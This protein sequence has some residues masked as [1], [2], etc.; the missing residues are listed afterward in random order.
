MHLNFATTVFGNNYLTFL[1][2]LIG[3]L[4]KSIASFKLNVFYKDIQVSYIEEIN[5]SRINFIDLNSIKFKNT[6]TIHH[7]ISSKIY[8]WREALSYLPYGETVFFLDTDTIVNKN[9]AEKINFD[10]NILFTIKNEKRPINTGVIIVKNND[11]VKDFFE[12]WAKRTIEIIED[13]NLLNIAISKNHPYG[14]ADQMSFYE[15][16]NFNSY[17]NPFHLKS[18]HEKIFTL[19]CE[20]FNQTNSV[21]LNKQTYIYHFKGGWHDV[22][23]NGKTFNFKRTLK[24]SREM[25]IM[26]NKHLTDFSNNFNIYNDY[27]KLSLSY[28]N[29]ESNSINYFKYYLK[30]SSFYLK[31]ILEKWRTKSH[32]KK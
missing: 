23:L 7:L 10:F 22:I 13:D 25:L 29:F 28:F 31:I 30:L 16:V 17:N 2:A 11:F 3:S 24:D 32:S 15:L 9:P 12:R 20:N 27:S 18:S 21:K 1:Y 5:D 4:D 14:G 8:L 6:K 19:E 26:F